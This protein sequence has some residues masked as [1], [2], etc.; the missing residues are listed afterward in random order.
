MNINDIFDLRVYIEDEDLFYFLKDD[1]TPIENNSL[2]YE[3]IIDK[4]PTTNRTKRTK[5]IRG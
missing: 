1:F 3:I 2:N 4:N 5:A